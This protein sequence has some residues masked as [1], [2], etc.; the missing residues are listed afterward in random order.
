MSI[1]MPPLPPKLIGWTAAIIVA[2]SAWFSRGIWIPHTKQWVADSIQHFRGTS[3]E[4]LG[5]PRSTDNHN[6]HGNHA[7]DDSTSLELSEQARRNI[8]LTDDLIKEVKWQTF[9]REIT[10]PAMVVERPG[11]TQI[12]VATPMTGVVTHVHAVTGEAVRSGSLLF[13]L[14]LTHEDLVSAQTDFLKSVG[15]LDV[16]RRELKRLTEATATGAIAKVRLLERQYAVEKIEALIRA[17]QEA[18]RLHGLSERQV[19]QIALERKLLRELHVLAPFPDDHSE[20]ELHLASRPIQAAA[21]LQENDGSADEEASARSHLVMTRLQV[22][23]GQAV[24]AG[25][26]LCVMSDMKQLYVEGLT[27]E[28]DADLLERAIASNWPLTAVFPSGRDTPELIEN[29]QVEFVDNQISTDARALKF[30]VTIPNSVVRTTTNSESQRF[31][32]WKYRTGQRLQLRIPVEEWT[33]RIVLPVGAV[34][35]EGAEYFVFMQ[36]GDHFHRRA[37]HVEYRDQFNVVIANDGALFEG[38]VIAFTGAHQMQMAL[39]KKSGGTPD[40]HAGHSH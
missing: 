2:G 35:K 11:R 10:V 17:Q 24:T 29:L 22:H 9:R 34:E 31:I 19:E 18:L 36:N 38:D 16:E 5:N 12:Q 39:K 21:F 3:G 20:D 8:G 33:N 32:T 14:R 26:T 13:E 27:F 37:V 6:D 30:Y 40:P 15:E 28:Q 1:Q 25:E 23:K 4:S 7:H